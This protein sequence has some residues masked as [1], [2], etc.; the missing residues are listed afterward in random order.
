MFYRLVSYS[1]SIAIFLSWIGP[2]NA[3]EVRCDTFHGKYDDNNRIREAAQKFWP[4]GRRPVAGSTCADGFLSGLI[5][6]GDYERVVRFYRANHP[7]LRAFRLNSPGGDVVEAIKI[8]TLFRKYLLETWAP[9]RE[10]VYGVSVLVGRGG[11]S[12]N[13]QGGILCQG[14]GCVCASACALIWFGGVERHGSVGLHR[15]RIEDLA[16]KS[17]APADASA[18]YR[19]VLDN[20]AL[21]LDEMEAPK[22]II[23]STMATGS[24]EIRWVDSSKDGLERPPSI[25][26]W[27]DASCGSSTASEE[28]TY[29]NLMA[30]GSQ[31]SQ[32]EQLLF[33][34]LNEKS[35]EKSRCR[36]A[37]I[38]GQR[39][40]LA[41]P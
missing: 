39:D 27:E 2:A 28:E 10:S 22:P 30:K 33:R 41:L 13:E 21:Y 9:I 12:M 40:R 15:P 18:V 29:L 25:A 26:E 37:L 24:A 31:R 4:S 1:A 14:Q 8:G 7:F 5:S 38:S 35:Q 19:R 17:L 20:I 11:R 6:K 16:F 34:L 23:E 32:Q 3:A 36:Y